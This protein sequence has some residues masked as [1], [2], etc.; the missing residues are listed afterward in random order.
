MKKTTVTALICIFIGIGIGY[1]AF[2]YEGKINPDTAPAK[3]SN[4]VETAQ[5][6]LNLIKEGDY[7]K[8]S[9]MVHPVDGVYFS[10]Y[11]NID[12]KTDMHFTAGQLAKFA[13]DGT[14]Y[15]WGYTDGE[16]A[17]IELT[18]K[19]YFEKYVFDV[20]YTEAPVIGRN[21]I[22]K[23]GNSIENVQTV[24]PDCQFVEFHFP[25]IDK[26]YNGMDWRSLRLVFREYQGENKIVAIV[27]DQWTV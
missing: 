2:R 8:L 12:L 25:E 6:A 7:A 4:I 9:E 20:D 17:P 3:E 26:Q 21:Y 14:N 13:A 18:P 24:F 27:H 10:P 19:K 11:S 23:S 5:L 15:L 1:L 16:G 22:V